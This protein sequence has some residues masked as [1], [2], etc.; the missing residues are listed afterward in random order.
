MKSV[1]TVSKTALFTIVSSLTLVL[2]GCQKDAEQALKATQNQWVDPNRN[3]IVNHGKVVIK[4]EPHGS[5]RAKVIQGKILVYEFI[6][7]REKQQ[8]LLTST[9]DNADV[10]LTGKYR[11]GLVIDDLQNRKRY[12]LSLYDI[13]NRLKDI[14]TYQPTTVFIRGYA[15]GLAPYGQ[16]VAFNSY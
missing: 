14:P 7:D 13:A 6:L 8:D 5:I 11:D 9:V 2:S 3:L 16:L 1:L 12:V 10:Y 4:L 15:A